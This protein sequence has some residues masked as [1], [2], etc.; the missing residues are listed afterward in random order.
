MR[1]ETSKPTDNEVGRLKACVNDL[2]SLL[3]LPAIFTGREP[4]Q[5][6]AALLDVLMGILRL[7]A[8]YAEIKD[9]SGCA[10]ISMMRPVLSENPTVGR[11]EIQASQLFHRK[12]QVGLNAIGIAKSVE[13]G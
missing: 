9:P 5:I 11:L 8:A 13:D 12:A 1:E 10:P 6:I 3:A 7:D 4:D 2:T